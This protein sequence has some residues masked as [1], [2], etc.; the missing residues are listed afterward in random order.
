[1][2]KIHVLYA[3]LAAL[4]P[5]LTY[6]RLDGARLLYLCCRLIAHIPSLFVRQFVSSSVN[7]IPGKEI[8]TMNGFVGHT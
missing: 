2:L 3:S 5:S 6:F 8:Q 4:D 7:L 1:M